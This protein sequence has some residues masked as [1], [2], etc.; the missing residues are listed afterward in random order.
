MCK[1][2]HAFQNTKGTGK[3]GSLGLESAESGGDRDEL[4]EETDGVEEQLDDVKRKCGDSMEVEDE[5]VGPR[6]K[7][8]RT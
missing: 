7:R 5:V 1:K 2:Y 8:S 6:P 3:G 4:E